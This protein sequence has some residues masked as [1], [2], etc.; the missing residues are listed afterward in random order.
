MRCQNP[1]AFRPGPV[2]FWTTVIYLAIAIPLIY[3]HETVPPGPANRSL[4]RGLNLTEAFQDLQN[5]TSTFHPY[6]SHQNDRV[7]EFIVM[8]SK[9]ILDRNGMDYTTDLSGG[10]AWQDTNGYLNPR[11]DDDEISSGSRPPGVTLFDDQISNLTW[12]YHKYKRVG[13]NFVNHTW[14]AQYFEG[15]NFYIYIHGKDDPEGD[16]W[17]TRSRKPFHGTG[18]VMVNC[19]FD[20][21]STGYGAT[22]DGMGCV[23]MLQLL[24]YFTSKDHQ[25]R[26]G[27]V[28]LFNNAEEDGLLGAQAFG[29]SPL[30]PFVHT[31]VNLEGAGAGGRA[32]LFRT[33]D[34]QAAKAYG[35][36]P[37]PF[38][39]VVAANAF[40]A[41]VVKSATDFQIWDKSFGQRGLDIAFYAPRARYHSNEDDARHA[42]VNS[43]W[44]MLSAALASTEKLSQ[45]TGT[46]FHGPR[47]DKNSGKVYNGKQVQ[48]VWFDL[49]G[50]VWATLALRGLFAWSL[51]LLVATPLI[52]F[53]ITFLLVRKDKYY[54]F[55][56]DIKTH[57]DSD[58]PVAL[59]GWKGFS[60]FPLAF[61]FAAGL[62]IASVFLLAKFNPLIV[63]SSSYAVFAMSLS[64]FY[65]SFWL[66]MRGSSF[67]RP[68]ALHRGFVIFWLFIGGWGIQVVAALAED[69]WKIGSLYS[70]VFLQSAVFLSLA[71]S[72]LE[73][74]ALLGKHDFAMQLHDA[75][76]ARDVS[77]HGVD[78][79]P[80]IQDDEH[81]DAGHSDNASE[82][83][84]TE[85]TPLR[86]S[87]PGYGAS[88]TP[89][90]FANTYRRSVA[91]GSPSP[92]RMRRYQPF[93]HEQSWSGRL[94]SW[95]W[96][97]QFLLL[98]PIPC[99]L[100][101]NLGLIAMSALQ[102]TGT[103]GG[104]L[105]TPLLAIGGASI[106]F[107]VPITPFMHR[108]THHVPLFLLCVFVGTFIYNLVAFP[109]SDSHRFK[110]YFQQVLDLDDGSNTVT[111][112]GLEEFSRA[113][114][115][116]LPIAS[117]QE[118]ECGPTPDRS[119]QDCLYDG[120]ALAPNLV[121]GKR[122]EELISFRRL[123]AVASNTV[124]IQVDAL[125]TRVCYVTTSRP[126][127][128]FLVDGAPSI[129]PRFGGSPPDGITD[130]QLWRRDRDV[131]WNL[132]I[133]IG[134]VADSTSEYDSEAEEE[135]QDDSS[136]ADDGDLKARSDTESS[137]LVSRAAP[138]GIRLSCAWSDANTPGIIPAFDE[139]VQYMPTWATVTKKN[140]G[141]VEVRKTFEI[142]LFYNK[143][144]AHQPF[145]IGS[146]TMYP[147]VWLP[148]GTEKGVK[149][150]A[151]VYF[152][153]G[154]PGLIEYYTD[155][156]TNLRGLLQTSEV[157]T[158]YDI[159]GR[160][161]LGFSDDDHE[162]FGEGNEPW[163]LDGQI[164][165]IYDDVAA[166][167]VRTD[168]RT[169]GR[170]YDFVVLMGH[171]VGS[172]ISVEIFHRHMKAPDRAPHLHLRY[173]FLLFP[174]LTHIGQ[175]PS[176]TRVE[177]VRRA[178]PVLDRVA[179]VGAR[180]ILSVFP[181]RTLAWIVHRVMGFTASTAAV[182]AA[183]LKSRDG[184]RQAMHLGLSELETIG[185]ERWGEE[186]WEVAEQYED[187]EGGT[188]K[189]FLFYGRED[190]WVADW[191]RDELIERRRE[192][193]E[194]GGRTKIE[195]A[196]GDV[197]HA[198]CTKDGEFSGGSSNW[199]MARSVHEW[200]KEIDGGSGEQEKC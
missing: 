62:T 190:H 21:V 89:T 90:S 187:A 156:L 35:G 19:H 115:K 118:I 142:Q 96:I 11:D 146:L 117:N 52:L 185:E 159:Y 77:N 111:I 150:H 14:G 82:E 107:L 61:I 153:C 176:G 124:R 129:D 154:N 138:L 137:E 121:E 195:V 109:F 149:R 70:F 1:F 93:N 41:G 57:H 38:G 74:F 69:R 181:Q 45:T 53:V 87:E 125:D 17:H 49:F 16:W 166:K 199:A 178:L 65:F 47:S 39:T 12:T 27:I 2:S 132:T 151:L 94:P 113:V 140:V 194:R 66:V 200:I 131:P 15:N 85:R 108:I 145:S 37:H 189:F 50:S 72:L 54:F 80:A 184:V 58:D 141:L 169:G 130:L 198:F 83:T 43:L 192:H 24:S 197:P 98:A 158:A 51:T 163:D 25:P 127:R 116:E 174:T 23:S 26:N 164:E 100:F 13:D 97:V 172:Y 18:G 193:G 161:L 119:L 196:E 4:Y 71:I 10:V 171:S 135:T 123:K 105:L 139:L 182:T 22:D 147:E 64:L 34:L 33:T 106:L 160:N 102:M 81:S 67:V 175:S 186:L 84:A 101:G 59:G 56:K 179:H 75:H 76:Q 120:S 78:Q 55:A 183:W 32:L 191:A 104:T 7:R 177:A 28:L 167:R 152:V 8:R 114:I 3:V 143:L 63:Y 9:E 170:P 40:E 162:P 148:S 173:G 134:S 60:R 133:D 36:S 44:H 168:D 31:F 29:Y 188:A 88:N 136:A 128:A 180:L 46:D 157:E 91:E 165:G 95:T 126:I 30:L 5:I 110:L 155:F 6:N 92:P 112:S 99:I 42:S 86:A 48:G 103:D 68:S 79:T 20:S 73:Q 122:A 144:T